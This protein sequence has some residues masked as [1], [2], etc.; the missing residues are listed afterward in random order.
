MFEKKDY[1]E[2]RKEKP[3]S[4]YMDKR[5]PPKVQFVIDNN[6]RDLRSTKVIFGG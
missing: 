3:T 2:Y 4:I 5:V 1:E 6:G